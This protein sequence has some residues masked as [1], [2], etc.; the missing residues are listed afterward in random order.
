[1][2]GSRTGMPGSWPESLSLSQ[3]P[4]AGTVSI[5]DCHDV[6]SLGTRMTGRKWGNWPTG[7]HTHSH[8][9]SRRLPAVSCPRHHRGQRP[10]RPVV[11]A[12]TDLHCQGRHIIQIMVD[13]FERYVAATLNLKLDADGCGEDGLYGYLLHTVPQHRGS[14]ARRVAYTPAL[15]RRTR[16]FF[17]SMT[18]C[19][20]AMYQE[21][22]ERIKIKFEKEHA[23]NI[24]CVFLE[25]P[26]CEEDGAIH[27]WPAWLGLQI[28][29][30]WLF[31]SG[32][33]SNLT[34]PD[35]HQKKFGPVPTLGCFFS[36]WWYG[37][38]L[39]REGHADHSVRLMAW[40]T[41]YASD[42]TRDTYHNLAPLKAISESYRRT[43]ATNRANRYAGTSTNTHAADPVAFLK[44]LLGRLD[45]FRQDKNKE[46][47][48]LDYG[49]ITID[50]TSKLWPKLLTS[51]DGFGVADSVSLPREPWKIRAELLTLA[52][53]VFEKRKGRGGCV[54]VTRHLNYTE[55]ERN[56]ETA[57][58][59]HPDFPKTIL[60]DWP[61]LLNPPCAGDTT[62]GKVR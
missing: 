7:S 48:P 56:A 29:A 23:R 10:A 55:I 14:Q 44:W 9:R 43:V 22:R 53:Q 33:F 40:L 12:N 52:E 28:H 30:T 15:A 1:M 39:W 38:L 51:L 54:R 42:G 41:D 59:T 45:Y 19:F 37:Y 3:R 27:T 26:R 4:T 8:W 24:L 11:S 57:L 18:E 20:E 21:H 58:G 32:Y 34:H 36:G 16:E 60:F 31:T 47:E 49:W 62:K 13:E 25:M 50:K 5:G 46:I 2:S 6:Y 61:F 17:R 35:D